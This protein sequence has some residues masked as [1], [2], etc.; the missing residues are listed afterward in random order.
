MAASTGIRRGRLPV[1]DRGALGICMSSE[2]CCVSE[3][4]FAAIEADHIVGLSGLLEDAETA[5]MAMEARWRAHLEQ[6]HE[7][8]ATI[9]SAASA[10][11]SRL[12][13]VRGA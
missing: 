13:E 7:I 5:G 2:I 12:E 3:W 9:H 6:A 4:L 11:L 1:R 8:M 10:L